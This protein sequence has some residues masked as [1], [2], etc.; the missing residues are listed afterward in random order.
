MFS[1][2]GHRVEFLLTDLTRKLLFGIAM[3][4]LYMLVE[5]PELLKGLVAC[6]TLNVFLTICLKME[7]QLALQDK[8]LAAFVTNLHSSMCNVHVLFQIPPCVEN[9]WTFVT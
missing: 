9:P 3:D 7:G 1:D 2:M 6:D 8:L 4:D 5:G